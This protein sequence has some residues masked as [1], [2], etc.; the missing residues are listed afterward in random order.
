MAL[1]STIDAHAADAP[2]GAVGMDARASA[3]FVGVDVAD[4]HDH[5]AVHDEGLDRCPASLRALVQIGAAE[6]RLERFRPQIAQQ[7]MRLGRRG[8]PLQHAEAARIAKAQALTVGETE[9][10]MIMRSGA[11]VAG[12]TRRLPDMP[13]CSSN[14]PC[15]RSNSRYLPRRR[16]AR[17]C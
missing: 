16:S 11:V 2:G 5:L 14:T 12:S 9:I 15:S 17:M 7:G 13:K 8:G 4:A 6:R 1:A 10:D 3:G